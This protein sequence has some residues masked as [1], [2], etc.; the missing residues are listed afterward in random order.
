M[1][2]SSLGLWC[3]HIGAS[4]SAFTIG[5]NNYYTTHPILKSIIIAEFIRTNQKKKK[6]EKRGLWPAARREPNCKKRWWMNKHQLWRVPQHGRHDLSV[7]VHV[8]NTHLWSLKR[9]AKT[10]KPVTLYVGPLFAVITQNKL[11]LSKI[12]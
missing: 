5:I 4:G 10:R 9:S 6:K 8:A 2:E 12:F 1:E 3:N 11:P 7:N